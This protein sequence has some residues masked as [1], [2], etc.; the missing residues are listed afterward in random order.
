LEALDKDMVS[1]FRA[2]KKINPNYLQD[3]ARLSN[4]WSLRYPCL[5]KK[6]RRMILSGNAINLK[7]PST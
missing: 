4:R 5:L 6:N 3:V 1:A 2:I 7:V